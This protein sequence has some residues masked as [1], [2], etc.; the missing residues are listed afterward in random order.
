[1]DLGQLLF[2]FNGRVPRRIW[3]ITVV[4]ESILGLAIAAA[5]RAAGGPEV[6]GG[7]ELTGG[8]RLAALIV[9][10]PLIWIG[11]AIAAKRWHDIDFSAW[12]I[13]VGIVPLVGGLIALVMNGFVAGTRTANRFGPPM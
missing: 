4:V 5:I 6:T 3:W 12:W 2:S 10:A 9:V 13:L 8:L 1:M 7:Q 11:L